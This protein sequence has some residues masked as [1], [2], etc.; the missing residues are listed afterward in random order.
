MS[1]SGSLV[2]LGAEVDARF[3]VR[4][5]FEVQ[6]QAQVQVDV[7]EAAN[8]A[9]CR[10][11]DPDDPPEV[12]AAGTPAVVQRPGALGPAGVV[13][14]VEPADQVA[15]QLGA[16]DRRAVALD[17]DRRGQAAQLRGEGRRDR[18]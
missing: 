10:R 9:A 8:Q 13:P 7:D 6:G 12:F 17:L 2:K 1:A 14:V 11:F 4:L 18:G 16:I 15:S 3:P 5:G